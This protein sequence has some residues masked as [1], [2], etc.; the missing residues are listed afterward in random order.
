MDTGTDFSAVC[1]EFTAA[2]TGVLAENAV[3]LARRGRLARA[4]AAVKK[5]PDYSEHIFLGGRDRIQKL[6]SH[7]ERRSLVPVLPPGRDQL[8][9]TRQRSRALAR[10]PSGGA[11]PW[12][13][14]CG[15]AKRIFDYFFGAGK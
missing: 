4:R 1:H 10:S 11:S 6:G 12:V 7:A 14:G 13:T 15:A 5:H 9:S 3:G 8:P 2:L